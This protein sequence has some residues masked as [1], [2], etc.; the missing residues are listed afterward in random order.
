MFSITSFSF[1]VFLA[2]AVLVYYCIPSKIRWCWLLISSAIFFVLSSGWEMIPYLL[3]GIVVTYTGAWLIQYKC[4]TDRQ[5]KIVLI[6]TLILTLIE[7]VVLKYLNFFIATGNVFGKLFHL[8][9]GL[10]SLSMIA[11]IG[12]SYYTLS[13]IGYVIDVYRQTIAAQKNPFKFALFTCYFPQLVSGPIT[14]YGEMEPQFFGKRTFDPKRI[15]FGLERMLWGLFKKLVISDRLAIIVSTVYAD[16]YNYNGFY[17]LFAVFIFAFRLYADFSGCMD[18]VLG[19][20][21]IFGI[22]LP[23]NFDTPFFSETISEFWR[24]WHI[25]LGLWS[26]DYILYPLL[27]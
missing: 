18:I 13:I 1:F 3:Y 9:I 23:E 8:N 2:L 25:T 10:T 16:F 21:E 7:L 15:Q 26:K 20:S 6:I 14:R 17:I 19:A 4:K 11:P 22:T 12:I 27:K 5:R 24:R